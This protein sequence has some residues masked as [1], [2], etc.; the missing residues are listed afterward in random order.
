[1]GAKKTGQ[2]IFI[3]VKSEHHGNERELKKPLSTIGKFMET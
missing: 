2:K 3:F 1:M